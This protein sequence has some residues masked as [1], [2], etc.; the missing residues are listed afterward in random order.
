M[1]NTFSLIAS[2]TVGAGGVASIDFTSIPSTYTDLVVKFSLRA[3]NSLA[4]NS[5]QLTF[6]NSASGYSYLGV[7]GNASGAASNSNTGTQIEF[8]WTNGATSTASNFSNCELYIPNYTVATNKSVSFELAQE[9]NSNAV[10]SAL[11]GMQTGLWSN[12]AAITSVKLTPGSSASWVQYS[13]AYLY[14]IKN[15]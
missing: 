2:S 6:N 4:Y 10:N 7:W 3:S 9:N 13:T 12:T 15:S 11:V 8:I 1:A 5:S 14:G